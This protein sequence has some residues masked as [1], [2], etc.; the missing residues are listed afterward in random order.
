VFIEYGL[1]KKVFIFNN[2]VIKVPRIR[3][4]LSDSILSILELYTEKWFYIISTKKEKQYLLPNIF[5][6]ILPINIMPKVEVLQVDDFELSQKFY[7]DIV[8]E[9]GNAH[10]KFSDIKPENLG[11]YKG[12]I[13]KIDY[14]F[15]YIFHNI[16]IELKNWCK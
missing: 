12:K 8:N 4:S 3:K 6:P 5:I 11:K 15:P 10:Y 2:F 14:G 9:F 7:Q 16:L 1:Y 13:V